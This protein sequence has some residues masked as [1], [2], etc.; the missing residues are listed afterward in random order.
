M[1]TAKQANELREQAI[2]NEIEE[3]RERAS[4]YCEE[5]SSLIEQKAK[6]KHILITIEVENN[7]RNYVIHELT[8][9]GYKANINWNN[10]ITVMW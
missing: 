2:E 3:R 8:S 9:N 1:I 4:K 6:E 5:L 10:T 7:I